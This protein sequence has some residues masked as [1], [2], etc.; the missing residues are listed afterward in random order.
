MK[1]VKL[2][3]TGMLMVSGGQNVNAKMDHTWE[4]TDI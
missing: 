1:V 3:H 2:Q 4:E